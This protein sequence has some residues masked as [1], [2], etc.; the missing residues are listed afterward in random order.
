M[1]PDVVLYILLSKFII[2]DFPEPVLPTIAIDC[3]NF[4]SNE[5]FSRA[6]IFES[7]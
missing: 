3:P 5:I 7:G 2:V 1:L 6:L 4:I